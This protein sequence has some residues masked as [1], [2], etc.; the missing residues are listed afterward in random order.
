MGMRMIVFHLCI[1]SH[2]CLS[3]RVCVAVCARICASVCEETVQTQHNGGG[4]L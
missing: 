4:G 1:Y 2:A 3:V